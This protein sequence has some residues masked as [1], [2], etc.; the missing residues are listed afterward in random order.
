MAA[1]GAAAPADTAVLLCPPFGFDE[2]C[3]YRI[4]RE[5]AIRL[6]RAGHPALRLTYPSC[7]D[8][9]AA[10]RDPARL[11]AW[12][13]SVAVAAAALRAR[14]GVSSVV[15][16][17]L[18]LGALLAY[19]AVGAGARIDGR[20]VIAPAPGGLASLA[21]AITRLEAIGAPIHQAGLEHPAL[22]EVFG[23]LTGDPGPEDTGSEHAG[24]PD[25]MQIRDG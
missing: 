18:G 11:D 20:A 24:R 21:A 6:A 4:V 14:A 25:S 1:S 12:T 7:G 5:W 2:L 8:S 13:D 15:A 17:G 16:I 10:P 23:T 19:R 3:A 9:G 22:D